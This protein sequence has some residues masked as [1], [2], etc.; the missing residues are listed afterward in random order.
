[1]QKIV[2]TLKLQLTLQEQGILARKTSETAT[3][4][5]GGVEVSF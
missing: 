3:R 5:E 4:A 1:V 2:I